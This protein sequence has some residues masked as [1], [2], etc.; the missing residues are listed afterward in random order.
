MSSIFMPVFCTKKKR[1][2]LW[3]ENSFRA[4]GCMDFY[5][6][7]IP[8]EYQKAYGYPIHYA[9]EPRKIPCVEFPNQTEAIM[10]ILRWS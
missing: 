9:R 5:Y 3:F 1:T 4:A 8:L 10:F 2:H 7:D 6:K